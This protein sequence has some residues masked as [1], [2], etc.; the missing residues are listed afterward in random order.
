MGFDGGRTT[1]HQYKVKSFVRLVLYIVEQQQ[2]E[3]FDGIRMEELLEWCPDQKQH[4]DSISDALVEDIRRQFTMSPLLIYCYTCLIGWMSP[5]EKDELFQ[6]SDDK[7]WD[8]LQ[9]Q[10]TDR[11]DDDE[12]VNSFSIG[13]HMMLEAMASGS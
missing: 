13:P 3:V 10:D 7:I 4:C 1:S 2:L 5:E 11:S 6:V 9:G 12:F 8:I